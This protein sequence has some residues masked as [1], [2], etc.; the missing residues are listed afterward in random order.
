MR[1]WR[2]GGVSAI[3]PSEGKNISEESTYDAILMQLMIS[4]PL[5]DASVFATVFDSCFRR[6]PNFSGYFGMRKGTIL[7]PLEPS[8]AMYIS[9][10]VTSVSVY[11][12]ETNYNNKDHLRNST[13]L[14]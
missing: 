4:L 2:L 5:A 8:Y 9:P 13:S 14:K 12:K 11:D 7:R 6:G 1:R 3:L 10:L